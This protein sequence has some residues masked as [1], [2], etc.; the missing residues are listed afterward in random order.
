MEFAEFLE[1]ASKFSP[2][3]L[4]ITVDGETEKGPLSGGD[5]VYLELCG[6]CEG[7]SMENHTET[8]FTA[9]WDGGQ[10][11]IPFRSFRA[12]LAPVCSEE[13]TAQEAAAKGLDY[14]RLIEIPGGKVTVEEYGL[15]PGKTYYAGVAEETYTLPPRPPDFEPVRRTNRVAVISDKPLINGAPQGEKTP[16]FR[17]WSY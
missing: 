13:L 2:E 9:K 5:Y 12:Y 14:G 11:V 1:L 4:R 3:G 6:S 8:G 7:S 15:A 16:L 17:V 10:A